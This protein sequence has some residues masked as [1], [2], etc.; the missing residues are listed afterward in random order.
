MYFD[1][2]YQV[3]G[4]SNCNKVF[5]GDKGWLDFFEMCECWCKFFFIEIDLC[6]FILRIFSQVIF[7]LI[8]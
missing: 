8:I 5:I 4:F 6:E 1:V 2:G 7:W 3:I